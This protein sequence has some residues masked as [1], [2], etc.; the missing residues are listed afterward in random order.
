MGVYGK[1]KATIGFFSVE[2]G[3]IDFYARYAE[4]I[5]FI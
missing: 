4:R 1:Q 5:T 2:A 3:G